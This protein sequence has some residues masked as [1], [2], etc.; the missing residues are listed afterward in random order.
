MWKMS[1]DGGEPIQVTGN[2]GYEAMESPDGRFLYYNKF[3]FYTEGLFRI[4]V[5]GGPETTIF[6]LPQMDSFGDWTVAEEGIYYVHRYDQYRKLTSHFSINLFDFATG[7][8]TAVAA[9]EKDPVSH[10]G[11]NISPDRRSLIYSS[12][13]TFNHDIMLVKNFR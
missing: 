13:D 11:L 10:P 6:D 3:G 5:E 2:G 8:V 9:L 12:N 4:P 1:V 7:K